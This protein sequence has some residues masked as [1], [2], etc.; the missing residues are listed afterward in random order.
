[1][2]KK[3]QRGQTLVFGA[4]A[5]TMLLGL[6]GLG[7]DMGVLRYERR[8]QQTA[9]DAAA[10]A[11]ASN[12]AYTGWQAGG[13]NAATASGYTDGSGNN[14]SQ[15]TDTAV[16]GTICVEVDS[17]PKD[18]TVNGQIVPGGPH[19]TDA[20]YAQAIVAVVQPTYFMRIF[21]MPQ[22][23]VIA[24]AVATSVSGG[25]P[26]TG[27]LYTLDPPAASIEG[28]NIN[29]SATLNAPTCGIADNGNYNTQGNALVVTANTFGVSGDANQS[30]PGGTVTCTSGQNPC[31][32]YGM[33]AAAD[34]LAYLTPPCSPCTV[35]TA[36]P[37]I[38]G[39]GNF[40]LN[41][42]VYPSISI[43]GTGNNKTPDVTFNPGIYVV[44]G[45]T[46]SLTGNSSLIGSGVM[47]Y[48]T[49]G[50]TI[51]ATGGGNKL[52]IQFSPMTTGQY[53]GILFYED[54]ADTASPSL[55]GDNKSFFD[56]I[57]YFPKKNLTFFGNNTSYATGM[58]VAGAITLSGNPT[59][60]FQGTAALPPG[61]TIVSSAHLVE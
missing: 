31:P 8:L 19:K 40:T 36:D 26:L 49:N 10:V 61:V 24:R 39:A 48:F 28:V 14:A 4:L 5:L 37:N 56:G 25:G 27:C 46:F 17:P 35:N 42:G 12:I 41:P 7:V 53:K 11:A 55:G 2:N 33:P 9:A 45:G 15:C 21:N 50:A 30:G 32:T 47:F 52:D 34:P 51:N 13:Q 29:G 22:R 23:T 18:V 44:T 6:A 57:L 20:N 43:S 16:V 58:V 59:V 3:N 54:P 38:S 60:N 1:M